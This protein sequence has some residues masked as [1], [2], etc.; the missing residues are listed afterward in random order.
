MDR[1]TLTHF[2]SLAS[3]MMEFPDFDFTNY[4]A[5]VQKLRDEF[6]SK[7][8]E[9]RRDEMRVNLLAHLFDLAVED[10]PGDFQM[11]LIERQADMDTKRGYSENSLVEIYKLNVCGK[12]P[13]LSHHA[14]KIISLFD[15]TYCFEQY[16]KKMKLIKTRCRRQLTDE[17]LTSQLRVAATSVKANIDKLCKDSKFQ[18]CH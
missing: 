12:F 11:E 10:S 14:I 13:N 18:V 16:L 8:P 4:A 5:S 7:F 17:H 9:F 2:T 15:S 6:T 1:V 3:R